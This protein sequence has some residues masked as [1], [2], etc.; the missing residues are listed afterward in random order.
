ML[1]VA[2]DFLPTATNQISATD[3][4]FWLAAIA[5][6][7]DD[8]IVGKDLDGI[9]ISWNKV[10]ETLFG[11]QSDEII[12]QP[13]TS[14]LPSYLIHEE[15]LILARIRR[16][17][18][19]NHFET[20]RQHKDGSLV[21]VSLTV[22]PI[23]SAQNVVI[24]AT[25]IIR[26][27]TERDGRDA[28][29]VESEAALVAS[30]AE[31]RTGA[32]NL[33]KAL[34]EL[35]ASQ[36]DAKNIKLDLLM[37]SNALA[38]SRKDTKNCLAELLIAET[39]LSVS[40]AETKKSESELFAAVASLAGARADTD[41]GVV[42]RL[43][44]ETALAL[45]KAETKD[46]VID[47]LAAVAALAQAR[48]DTK[49]GIAD[50]LVAEALNSSLARLSHHLA[51]ARNV[52]ERANRAK[53]RFL[54]SMSHELRTPL[55]GII[56]Y[57]HLL[58]ADGGLSQVQQA[59]VSAMLAAGKHLL[60]MIVSVLD[61]SEI[62]ADHVKLR[63]VAADPKAIAQACLDT[64]RPAAE[65]K[66]LTL[67]LSAAPDMPAEIECDPTRLRQ[68]LLNLLGNAVKFTDSGGVGLHLRPLACGSTMRLEV[69][70]TGPG[71]SADQQQRLFSAFER[72][73]IEANST[74]EGA[75][76]GLA[77]SSRLATLMGGGLGYEDNPSGGS[78]FWLELPLNTVSPSLPEPA[79]SLAS[80]APVPVRRVLVVDDVLMNRDI[81]GSILRVGGHEVTYA[82]SGAEAV[83]A[84]ATTDFDVILMDVRMPGMDGLEA[85]RRIRKFEGERGRVPI[86]ALTAQA[87]TDQIAACHEAGMGSHLSKPFDPATLLTI[88]E[89]AAASSGPPPTTVPPPARS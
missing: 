78:L 80:A 36:A 10:A 24:G 83:A 86:V 87:F 42:A 2:P 3:S 50:L 12:G 47:L 25:T 37:A 77:I 75:G 6:S 4:R 79:P 56:G 44:S 26:D 88:V 13:I 51:E 45:S 58:K 53:S 18:K 15:E 48:E 62:E 7:S 41:I 82:A 81:A 54:A 64:L 67:S 9:V 34:G 76:L 5:D 14:I 28:K 22:S 84:A 16:G 71:I 21:P 57:A 60:E 89:R 35:A 19:I 1:D 31:A 27:L 63:T 55:N 23:R 20:E 33:L 11:F 65:A 69:A 61:F 73:G 39:A 32:S 17:E 49:I 38:A 52:S 30:Q 74:V 43:A 29:L 68:V 66:G 72:F 85:T 46:N 40:R 59:R 70:D 8:A